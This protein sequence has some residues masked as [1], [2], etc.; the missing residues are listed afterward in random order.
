MQSLDNVVNEK[1]TQKLFLINDVFGGLYTK[2]KIRHVYPPYPTK[3]GRQTSVFFK[4]P[5]VDTATIQ[6]ARD[7]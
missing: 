1:K 7:K 3:C 5:I 4:R 2:N 6:Q